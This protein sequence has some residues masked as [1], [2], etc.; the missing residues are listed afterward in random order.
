METRSKAKQKEKERRSQEPP[1]SAGQQWSGSLNP[2]EDMSVPPTT[3]Q[4]EDEDEE[5][6]STPS[7]ISVPA[8]YQSTPSRGLGP[9]RPPSTP[10]RGLGPANPTTPGNQMTSMMSRLDVGNPLDSLVLLSRTFT[11]GDMERFIESFETL[12]KRKEAVKNLFNV[13]TG[14]SY[15]RKACQKQEKEVVD[16]FASKF[17]TMIAMERYSFG[18]NSF[19][20]NMCD[21]SGDGIRPEPTMEDSDDED[22]NE[23]TGAV[24]ALGADASRTAKRSVYDAV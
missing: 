3:F 20:S 9:A 6:P 2:A 12:E 17:H 15:A 23:I 8:K 18:R 10:S 1:M 7:R 19:F 21:M 24:E 11:V 5:P 22:L 13:W 4:L 14:N 16:T